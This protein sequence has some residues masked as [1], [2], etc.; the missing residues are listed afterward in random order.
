MQPLMKKSKV[1]LTDTCIQAFMAGTKI[2]AFFF[3]LYI[4]DNM[5][6]DLFGQTLILL[7]LQVTVI[8]EMK[9]NFLIIVVLHTHVGLLM[10]NQVELTVIHKDQT[11]RMVRVIV[12]IVTIFIKFFFDSNLFYLFNFRIR[13][14]FVVELIRKT[15]WDRF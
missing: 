13:L 9:K 4:C 14:T 15:N 10:E 3:Y 11:Q 12:A 8:L 2:V 6:Y 7:I 5:Q 1:C